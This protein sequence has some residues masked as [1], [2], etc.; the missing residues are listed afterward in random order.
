MIRRPPRSTLFPYTTL[1]RSGCFERV[2]LAHPPFEKSA[3]RL[4]V[5]VR[6]EADSLL[7]QLPADAVGIRQRAIVDEAKVLAGGK[8]VRVSRRNGRFRRHPCM[9]HGMCARESGETITPGNLG[10]VSFVL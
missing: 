3:G 2:P 5:V 10:R 1:F 4:G 8:R 7:F 9:P 6:L